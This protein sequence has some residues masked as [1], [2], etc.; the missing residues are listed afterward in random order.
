MKFII[1]INIFLMCCEYITHSKRKKR[2]KMVFHPRTRVG[3]KGKRQKEE[4][5]EEEEKENNVN[6]KKR[7][8][9]ERAL[10]YHQHL[11]THLHTHINPIHVLKNIIYFTPLAMVY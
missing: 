11:Y 2:T 8:E 6:K 3:N 10:H 9:R 1:I 5:E 7:R 4:Q